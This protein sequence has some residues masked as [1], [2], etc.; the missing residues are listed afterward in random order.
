MG[1]SMFFPGGILSLIIAGMTVSS[2]AVRASL[3]DPVR[4]LRYE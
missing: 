4:A 3:S 2:Q 1:I